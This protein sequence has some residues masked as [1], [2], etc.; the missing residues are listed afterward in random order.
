MYP[1]LYY[2]FKD[3]FGVEWNWLR[4]F[5]SFGFFVAL[6][7]VVAAVVLTR[8]L[9]RKEQQGL[10]GYTEETIVVGRP[11]TWGDLLLNFVLGFLLGYKIIGLFTAGSETMKDPQTFIF[12]SEGN[13]PAGILIGMVMAGLKWYEK[14]KQKLAKPEQRKVRIWAHDRVGDMVILAAVVGFIGAKIFHN[15][16]N[17]EELVRNP[18]E[19]LL[20]FS[21]LTF[22][23][24][25]ICAAIAISYYARK[26]KIGFWHLGDA[27]APALM[28][29]YAIGRIGCQVS[30]DGDWGILN[31]AYVTEPGGK[32]VPADTA[33]FRSTLQTHQSF[34]IDQFGSLD[35]VPHASVKAPGFLPDWMVAYTY[36]NNVINEGMRIPGCAEDHCSQLPVPVFPTPFYETVT[37]LIFFFVLWGL[38]KRVH[39]AGVIF[40]I[41]FILNGLE[42]FL[43]ERIRVNTEYHIFGM[44]PSQAEII[45]AFLVILGLVIILIRR[46]KK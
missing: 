36:P 42:R 2:A 33:Q 45:S 39:T 8:E 16:E 5:H 3:L 44:T 46:G 22:Y 41:Y 4:I 25:L 14:N 31:S 28:I 15:L 6:A 29:A 11:A 40:G 10:L 12:S 24:G 27:I 17:W 9:R 32:A 7:F 26:H 21:G 37:C 23:G 34:Y 43:V 13:L 35:S 20:S 18:I 1:N 38:R 19:S 30:G